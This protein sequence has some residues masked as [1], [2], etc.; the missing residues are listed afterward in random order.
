MFTWLLNRTVVISNTTGAPTAQISK[1]IAAAQTGIRRPCGTLTEL[2]AI[3]PSSSCLTRLCR[4]HCCNN[5]AILSTAFA[6]TARATSGNGGPRSVAIPG[7]P[8]ATSTTVGAAWRTSVS[9]RPERK[10]MPGGPFQRSR[11]A[12][13]RQSW[14]GAVASHSPLA[15][16]AIYTHQPLVFARFSVVDRVR[17][18]PA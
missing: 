9:T 8:R 13:R 10:S 14:L 7:A 2:R 16:R 5:R 17:H 4:R 11:H 15:E 18:D 12:G 3:G 1:P 6:N